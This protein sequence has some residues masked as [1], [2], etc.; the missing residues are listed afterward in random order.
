MVSFSFATG[1][2]FLKSDYN[3]SLFYLFVVRIY[4]MLSKVEETQM[5]A[6]RK[7]ASKWKTS[8][9]KKARK[10]NTH[11]TSE[12]ELSMIGPIQ[13]A[14]QEEEVL[15][16]KH[17]N[18]SQVEERG[19]AS[20]QEVANLEEENEGEQSTYSKAGERQRPKQK[21]R[22][23]QKTSKRKKSQKG[24]PDSKSEAEDP[25]MASVQEAV[26]LEETCEGEQ[27]ALSNVEQSMIRPI[28][29]TSQEEE[30]LQNE[31]LNSSQV[32]EEGVASM[33]EVVNLEEENEGEQSASSKTVDICLRLFVKL[34]KM[35]F[36]I[37]VKFERN[38]SHIMLQKKIISWLIF[39]ET[40][41]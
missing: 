1:N 36:V 39:D 19:V 7:M 37:M 28:Q 21:R 6:K 34:T 3:F 12:V 10:G 17:L 14:S 9:Q 24:K 41:N 35:F 22:A 2:N 27:S 8:K 25:S 29:H 15:Q 38:L 11:S 13:H 23:K 40:R 32:E 18:N 33:Q 20:M 5:G 31:H 4:T 16:N 30:V 26:N